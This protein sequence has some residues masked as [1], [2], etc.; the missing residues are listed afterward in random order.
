MAFME[1]FPSLPER[2]NTLEWRTPSTAETSEVAETR[3]EDVGLHNHAIPTRVEAEHA[4]DQSPGHSPPVPDPRDSTHG[5]DRGRQSRRS[6]AMPHPHAR[7]RT[8][9]EPK[10]GFALGISAGLRR[11]TSNSS[12]TSLRPTSPLRSQS[13]SRIQYWKDETCEMAPTCLPA[14]TPISPAGGFPTLTRRSSR[15]SGS[16]TPQKVDAG[17]QG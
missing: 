3:T 11:R 10:M 5:S 13:T 12:S 14:G 1:S 2:K 8:A 15:L 4:L 16:S 7:L 17:A 6:S 9:G